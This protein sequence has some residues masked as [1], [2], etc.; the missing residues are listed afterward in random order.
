MPLDDLEFILLMFGS[1]KIDIRILGEYFFLI[2]F[3][4]FYPFTFHVF[5]VL[6]TTTSLPLREADPVH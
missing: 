3:N 5:G 4:L 6:V 2:S 1:N